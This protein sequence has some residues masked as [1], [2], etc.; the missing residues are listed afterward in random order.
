MANPN[1]LVIVLSAATTAADTA[2]AVLTALQ[3]HFGTGAYTV[4]L[5]GDGTFAGG[6]DVDVSGYVAGGNAIRI[7]ANS[8]GA[9]THQVRVRLISGVGSAY[10]DSANYTVYVSL[11]VTASDTVDVT[12]MATIIQNALDSAFGTGQYTVSAL[13]TGVGIGFHGTIDNQSAAVTGASNAAGTNEIQAGHA[14]T[15]VNEVQ[16]LSVT[17][18]TG[19]TFTI[20]HRVSEVQNL[21]IGTASGTFTLTVGTATTSAL[22]H[23][24]SAAQIQAALEGLSTVGAGNVTVQGTT[25]GNFRI[26]FDESIR[27]SGMTVAAGGAS[28]TLTLTTHY[29]EATTDEIAYNATAAQVQS[30]L[31]SLAT[32]GTGN[33]TVA[34]HEGAWR[35]TFTNDQGGREQNLLV[36]DGSNLEK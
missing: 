23:T 7:F 34:M 20:T 16:D 28:A 30:A 35:V 25:E 9:T 32:I 13:I 24:A 27:T 4:V 15:A 11:G 6:E 1:T 8:A 3:T 14:S 2:S 10:F 21:A 5:S 17:R 31:E 29:A 36:M 33:V 12:A 18:A 19:G 26:R 22:A